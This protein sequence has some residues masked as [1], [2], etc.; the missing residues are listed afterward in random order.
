M[1]QA[2]NQWTRS[3]LVGMFVVQ[4]SALSAA[5]PAADDATGVFAM[6]SS[7]SQGLRWNGLS[8]GMTL[9][10]LER[11]DGSPID[12]KAMHTNLCGGVSV[13]RMLHGRQL[14]IDLMGSRGEETVAGIF[15][16]LADAEKTMA[17][18]DLVAALKQR[19]PTLQYKPS[20][21]EP[22]LTEAANPWPVYQ[23]KSRPEM[24][25]FLKPGEGV[26]IGLEACL[27]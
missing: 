23:L 1:W 20:R 26:Y 17:V 7:D 12:P 24:V 9:R 11:T 6:L 2:I 10:Q 19:I 13:R 15:I 4:A 8:V 3:A 21:H 25:I 18:A 5:P 16:P 27:G 14:D 22:A